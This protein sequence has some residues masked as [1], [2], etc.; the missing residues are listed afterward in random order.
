MTLDVITSVDG[1]GIALRE[2]RRLSLVPGAREL[3]TE[4]S[5]LLP[6]D[7]DATTAISMSLRRHPNNFSDAPTE[8]LLALRY[9]KPF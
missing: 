6:G 9:T 3:L 2:R 7:G 5:Y 1:N 8:K 4:A